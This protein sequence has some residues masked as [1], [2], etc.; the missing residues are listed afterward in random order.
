MVQRRAVCSVD[1]EEVGPSSRW[2]DEIQ[3][4]RVRQALILAKAERNRR[5]QGKPVPVMENAGTGQFLA[6]ATA[7]S[8]VYVWLRFGR[9]LLDLPAVQQL[10]RTLF[11]KTAVPRT[12]GGASTSSTSTSSAS[13]SVRPGRAAANAAASRAARA[14]VKPLP[15]NSP[16][17]AM[18]VRCRME[19]DTLASEGSIEEHACVCT[20]AR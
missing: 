7:V 4:N 14:T 1:L 6:M 17:L 2:S 10:R 5:R 9:K 12:T 20:R 16:V 8:S 19:L 15:P 3:S 13:T 11:G 18:P